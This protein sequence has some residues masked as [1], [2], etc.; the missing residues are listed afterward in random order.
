MD[1]KH[2]DYAEDND[3]LYQ[4][5]FSGTLDP[6]NLGLQNFVVKPSCPFDPTAISMKIVARGRDGAEANGQRVSVE[7]G[8]HHDLDGAE[9]FEIFNKDVVVPIKAEKTLKIKA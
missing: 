8:K 6:V 5:I 1:L 7:A 9:T 4:L 2:D 3:R